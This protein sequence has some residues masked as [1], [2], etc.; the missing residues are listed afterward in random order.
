MDART[1]ALFIASRAAGERK[2]CAVR[3]AAAALDRPYAEVLQVF[4]QCGRKPQ[5]GTQ[6]RITQEV[7]KR[8]GYEMVLIMTRYA[9]KRA[10]GSHET[11]LPVEGG[12]NYR[13][14]PI[15]PLLYR[16]YRTLPNDPRL[17][18]GVY[19]VSSDRHICAMIDGKLIDTGLERRTRI[20]EVHQL[21]RLDSPFRAR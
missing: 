8:Y 6:K 9:F 12:P 7:M 19:L 2:D 20:L 16:T 21:V 15:E 11:S 1:S 5:R 14:Q 18:S 13:V 10:D 4:T 3:A 17:Q